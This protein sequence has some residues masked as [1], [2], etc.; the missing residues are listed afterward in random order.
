MVVAVKK[1]KLFK[2]CKELNVG[3]DTIRPFLEDKGIKLS[4]PNT[5]LTEEIYLEILENFSREKEI[6]D[7]LYQRKILSDVDETTG[8][9]DDSGVGEV[10]EK[11]I[12]VQAIERSIEERMEEMIREE[13]DA[14]KEKSSSKKKKV[15]AEEE[16]GSEAIVEQAKEFIGESVEE[17]LT[18]ETIEIKADDEEIVTVEPDS[19]EKPPVKDQKK[20][21]DVIRK[22]DLDSIED[23]QKRKRKIKAKD[24]KI[25]SKEEAAK[26]KED[27]RRIALEMIRK[28]EKKKKRMVRPGTDTDQIGAAKRQRVRKPKKKVVDQKEIQDTVKKTLASIDDRLKKPKKRRK[29]K[30]DT[31][32]VVEEN[33]IYASEFISASDL[34]NLMDVPVGEIITKCLDLGLVVSINQRLDID[35]IELLAGEW[36]YTVVKEE[37]YA[38]DLLDDIEDQ[39]SDLEDDEPRAPIVTIMGHVDHGK[40]SLLDF[41]RNTNVVEGE[42]GGITQHI[43]AYEVEKNGH[44]ITF[45]DTPGHEAFTAMRA[46]GAQVTDIVILVIAADDQVKRQTDEAIDHARAAGVKM[47]IAINKIDKPESNTERIKQQLSE[48]NILVEDWG[49]T[50]Q[51][52][53][54]S[55][56]TGE[57]ID[58]LLEKVLLESDMLDLKANKKRRAS[59]TIIESRLDK[60]KGVI[61]S[62][63]VQNGT[64]KIGDPFLAGQYS[65]KVRAILNDNF[66]RIKK[67]SPSQ[68]V[69]VLGFDGLPQAGD[70][71]LVMADD[72]TVKEISTKRQRIKREQDYRQVKLTTLDQI[73]ESIKIGGVKELGVIVK[74]DVDGSA[75]ALSDSLLKLSTNEVNVTVVRKAVGPISESDVLLA[76]ASN[77]FI[78]AFHVRANIKAKELAVSEKVEIRYYKVVYDAIN[79]VR[80][81]LEGLLGTEKTEE[82][83]GTIEVRETF[84]ISRL[85]T[86]A[87]GHVKAGKISRNSRV[88]LFRDDVEVYEGTLSSLK[89]FKEDAKEVAAG[90]ECGLQIQNYNDIKVGDIIEVFEIKETKRTLDG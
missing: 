36:D 77:A 44:S 19:K 47:I 34:A 59:G 24:K 4:G 25:L 70:R 88:R 3:M 74:A 49:G 73:S 58:D 68:P 2:V 85:G 75:E 55:A 50:Y 48:R 32:E 31:G 33:L 6:A 30:D 60:G 46:R 83:V 53:E 8:D 72:H 52:A 81:A 84:K 26:E 10:V 79:E 87:G 63:L 12:Y 62:V 18:T 69:Q 23:G 42:S 78:V 64:L 82:N 41:I 65:G 86:I 89:R 38:S 13:V 14:K 45:L 27:K 80:L 20:E 71:F 40:T 56:K 15:T 29:I 35:T 1:Y 61:S 16:K 9:E 67:A 21:P 57:G 11:S 66:N 28:D 22:I 5:P 76:A 90:F 43:G 51:Y 54:I 39:E 7:Q 37:E 17:A